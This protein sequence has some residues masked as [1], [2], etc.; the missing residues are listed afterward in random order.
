MFR[1]WPKLL[2]LL[3]TLCCGADALAASNTT[4]RIDE[5]R[6]RL[7][8]NP[9]DA[10]QSA[11]ALKADLLK[12]DKS[13][14]RLE[15]I[16]SL[17][18]VEAASLLS[19]NRPREALAVAQRSL[20]IVKA[21]APGSVVQA[22]LL[23]ARGGATAALGRTPDAL[24]DYQAS[25]AIF[26]QHRQPRGQ[27]VALQ[28]IA[29]IYNDAHD[30]ANAL[31][32][33]KQSLDIYSAEPALAVSGYN[34]AAI[35]AYN[36]ADFDSAE[37]EYRNALRAAE[38]LGSPLVRVRLLQNIADTQIVRGRLDAAQAT[39]RQAFKLAGRP[40]ASEWRSALLNSAAELALKRHDL[41]TA[42]RLMNETL[43]EVRTAQA[44]LQMQ[45]IHRVAYEIYRQS[46]NAPAA[47]RH[48]EQFRKIDDRARTLAAS[49]SAALMSARFDFAN[50]DLKISRLRQQQAEREVAMGRQRAHYH[51][52]LGGSLLAAAMLVS[53]LLAIGFVSIR[54]SR[55]QVRAVNA[56]LSDTN[57]ELERALAARTEFLATTSHEIRTP[58]NGILGMTQVLLADRR[59]E[60]SVRARVEL[61]HGAGETMRALVDDILDVAK[62]ET[63]EFAV[64][65]ADMDLHRLLRD[66]GAIWT[67]Q[68]ETKQV[69]LTVDVGDTPPGIVADEVRLRQVVF[70]L[71]ANAVKFTDRGS[72][73]L[74]AMVDASEAGERLVLR[75]QD[76]GIGI[77]ADRL[78]D[79]FEAFRQVDGGTTRRHG[80]TGL[81]LAICR[82]I[83]RAMGGDVS[84]AS[85]PGAGSTFTL[86]LPLVRAAVAPVRR[87]ADTA[88]R[89]LADVVLLLL[90]PNPL[91]Q[92]ILRALIGPHVARLEVAGTPAAAAELLTQGGIDHLLADGGAFGCRPAEVASLLAG[93]GGARVTMLWPAPD[94]AVVAALAVAGADE[95]IAKPIAAP[96]LLVRLGMGYRQDAHAHELAA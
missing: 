64:H 17:D 86:R 71:M 18:W 89:S 66:A 43:S 57:V 39:L 31:K 2:V 94:E 70:N 44:P 76:S 90:E 65:P 48:L 35:A 19:L 75:V 51:L 27:A 95:V 67:G 37:A 58:L 84:V 28:H 16:G 12:G 61:I 38:K 49:T 20:N 42:M 78:Q 54:R 11:E 15:D 45:D 81:G 74:S 32:Y 33:S 56:T 9:A 83:A 60:Q 50:Q 40:P 13:A 26:G 91:A 1:R 93:A 85:V 63:G 24:R 8:T 47:L 62:M 72:V 30:Y 36:L 4:D 53:V 82:N 3:A 59:I 29:A 22:E 55:N 73:R 14:Y 5:I 80:G 77:P 79:I 21:R 23:L 25:F 96:E 92:G 69:A 68:A 34:N 87:A 6:S 88:D 10:L 41:P 7:F 46:G 52:L